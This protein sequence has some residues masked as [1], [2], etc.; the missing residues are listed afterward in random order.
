MTTPPNPGP[1]PHLF[2]SATLAVYAL[3]PVLGYLIRGSF[4]DGALLAGL[5]GAP[6]LSIHHRRT[7]TWLRRC[8]AWLIAQGVDP[9]D[10]PPPR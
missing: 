4:L 6:L 8:R 5:T 7:T 10:L 9:R 1:P 3:A 2:L